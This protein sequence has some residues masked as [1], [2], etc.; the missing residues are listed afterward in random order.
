MFNE[1]PTA[2]KSQG[3]KMYFSICRT[4]CIEYVCFY[5]ISDKKKMTE[6]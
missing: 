5:A 4:G 2:C 1:A 3:N 6:S